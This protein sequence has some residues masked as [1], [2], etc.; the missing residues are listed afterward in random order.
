MSNFFEKWA[1]ESNEHQRRVAQERL[2]FEVTEAIHLKMEELG[3]NRAY[4]AGRLGKSKAYVSQLLSGSRNMTLR[5]LADISFALG[6]EK[7]QFTF[8]L[9]VAIAADNSGEWQASDKIVRLSDYRAKIQE[10]NLPEIETGDE[11]VRVAR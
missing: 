10:V 8:G 9:Y 7:P 6:L 4:L 3:V 5:S 2:M 11:W 1:N